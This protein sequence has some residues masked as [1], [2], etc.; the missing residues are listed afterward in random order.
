MSSE[1]PKIAVEPLSEARWAK[2]DDALFTALD[3]EAGAGT[4]S[5]RAPGSD[6]ARV[7]SRYVWIGGAA[8]VALAASVL[9]FVANRNG[10]SA[11]RSD[12]VLNP[13]HIETGATP[14][15]LAVGES[16]IEIGPTSAVVAS[17]D[18][19]HGILVVVEKGQVDCEVTPRKDRP[20]FVVQAGNVRVRVVGTR[21]VVARDGGAVRVSVAHGAV[22]VSRGA[23]VTMLHDGESWP[24]AEKGEAPKGASAPAGSGSGTGTATAM[25]TEESAAA[26]ASAPTRGVSVATAP[27]GAGTVARDGK[28][29]QR[30]YEAA[31][32][33]ESSD[34]DG[35]MTAYRRLAGG[36]GAWA[37]TALFAAGRLAADRGRNAEAKRLLDDYLARY[38]HGANVEDARRILAR[39]R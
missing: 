4:A 33:S 31:A 17:G 7:R 9:L 22:E 19:A 25:A 27:V 8:A 5:P 35:A 15:R 39:L 21:F 23:D 10:G 20:P 12:V 6:V 29:A 32:R 11:G 3:A 2:V 16:T 1:R 24:A 30:I 28:D 36:G 37:P 34:P 18:D 26:T 13:S 14:S 38:P